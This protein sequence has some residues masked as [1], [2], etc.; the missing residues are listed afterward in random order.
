MTEAPTAVELVEVR[1]PL[2]RTFRTSFGI[3][4]AKEAVLVRAI[5]DEGAEGWGECA[6]ARIPAYSE[7][8]NDGAWLL[9]RDHLIPA[10]LSGAP[11][12]VKGHHM[13]RTAL[14]TAL[15]D[16]RLR[17]EGVSLGR[18]L[19]GVRDRVACGVSVGIEERIDDL[20]EVVA[21]HLEE[22]YRRIKLKIEPGWDLEPT[23]AVREAFPD[24]ALAVDANAAYGPEDAEHLAELDP[25]DLEYLEQPLAR[26]RLVA[27]GELQRRIRTPLCLD[28]TLTSPTVV[29]EAIRLGA[30]RVVNLKVGRV[31]GLAAAR[32]IHDVVEEHGVG[33]WCG[34]MLETGVGRA[35]NV[36]LASMPGFTMPGDTSASNRYF[37]RDLTEPFLLDADGTM[38]VPDGPG[39]GVMPI[40]EMLDRVA[41][42][43]E[44][45]TP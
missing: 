3:Q 27:H 7:E 13:A 19:G 4:T 9:L 26:D 16:L 21:A 41:V 40:P 45:I 6:A 42:R 31:G 37:E 38:A 36:A 25:L 43:R 1:L 34:G 5:G 20:L 17:R 30:C 14:E 8:W 35:V 39:I 11:A 12:R 28:E 18:H 32:Q 2:V 10:A 33:M 22:G 44:T 15:L 23:R 29:E 24:I